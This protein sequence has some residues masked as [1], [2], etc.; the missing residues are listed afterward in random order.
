MNSSESSGGAL[1]HATK[2]AWQSDT[3][4]ANMVV[5]VTLATPARGV[6]LHRR[7]PSDAAT[8]LVD[9]GNLLNKESTKTD[10]LEI[11]SST[12]TVEAAFQRKT[13]LKWTLS[14]LGAAGFTNRK[15]EVAKYLFKG[16]WSTCTSYERSYFLRDSQKVMI[17]RSL[18]QGESVWDAL[19]GRFRSEIAV[20]QMYP[21]MF[22]SIYHL[23]A[24]TFKLL[25]HERRPKQFLARNP[26]CD[27][28][29]LGEFVL[30]C[31]HVAIPATVLPSCWCSPHCIGSRLVFR[32]G[33]RW[34]PNAEK[35][36]VGPW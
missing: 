3:H 18:E 19:H 22:E 28:F 14:S 35:K 24:D 27:L 33:Q 25:K 13:T 31:A 20:S 6:R 29:A 10:I 15:L 5:Q 36:F 4:R 34:F 12:R 30:C 16:R 21:S 8:F 11:W 9:N 23:A 17:T 32:D 2:R 7:E 26:T 1:V